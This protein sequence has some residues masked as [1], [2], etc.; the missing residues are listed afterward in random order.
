M[1]YFFT[2]DLHLGHKNIITYCNRPFKSLEQMNATIIRNWNERVKDGDIVFH[3]G[4][5]CF[6]NSSNKK[7]E[8]IKVSASHWEKQLN[9]KIIHL[10]GNHDK[11]N[12]TKTIIEKL[13]IG[14]GN[15]RIN[16]VH[17]P[18][19]ADVDYEINFTG[20]VH[21]KWDIK[22]IKRGWQFTDCINVGVDVWNFMPVTFDEIMKKYHKWLKKNRYE[23]R[24]IF[25]RRSR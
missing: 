9:G 25:Y 18:E 24:K 2:A 6:K 14:Y 7:G 17:R 5:F 8:G 23:Q 12:S 21:Q 15:Q 4:D 3:V 16:L 13:T 10:K 19:F 1:K 22:R 11:N 20:H